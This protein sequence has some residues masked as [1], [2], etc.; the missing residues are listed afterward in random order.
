M[1]ALIIFA[2][3]FAVLD[4]ES[5]GGPFGKEAI[6]EIAV[7]RYDGEEV[8]DQLIS[9]VHPHREVQK[10]V[11]KMTGITPKMLARAPRF[12]E[13]AKRIIEITED[14]VV[15]G[16]NVEFDYRMLRQEFARLGYQYE[17]KTLDTI[18]LAEEL[19]P[20]L[21]A[22]GLNKVCEELGIYLV[23]KHRADSDARATL[24]LLKILQ[25]KDRQKNISVLGESIRQTNYQ[26]DK[27]ND[28][29]R[30]VK[31]NRGLFYL[32]DHEGKLLYLGASDKIRAALNRLLI[33]DNDRAKALRQ[34]ATSIR[35]EAVGNWL[36]ARIKKSGEFQ[37]ARPPFNRPQAGKLQTGLFVDTRSQPPVLYQMDLSEAGNKK[38]LAKTP[39][40]RLA[41]R[42]MRMF[43][44]SYAKPKARAAILELVKEF[45]PEAIYQGRGRKTSERCAFVVKDG[46]LAGYFYFSLHD[47]VAHAQKLAK[48]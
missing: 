31:I 10:F 8:V 13:V 27:V 48:K 39:G 23:N 40:P 1:A 44:R 46:Q 7:F 18:K 35:T 17:R 24:E 14:A 42:T 29:V 38:A 21:P 20:G 37:S 36:V 28:L 12:H 43:G 32:H 26:N 33:A 19:I 25:E 41:S 22:Y 16:H 11:S 2:R 4:I 45:P 34:Q 15:V 5:T 6:M 9:L 30:G 47:Q 3:M